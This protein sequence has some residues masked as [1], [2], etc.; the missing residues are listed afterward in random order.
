MVVDDVNTHPLFKG[1]RWGGSIVGLPLKGGGQVRAVMNVAYE[2][3]H[4]FAPEELRALEL[5]ADQAA[6]A[7]ENARYMAETERQLRDAQLLHRAGE[8]LN[9]T[10]SLEETLEQLADF[11]IQALD[12]QVCTISYVNIEKDE[13]RVIVD[14]DAMPETHVLPET[15]FHLSNHPHLIEMLREKRSLFFRRDAP[16]LNAE[17]AANMDAY[18]WKALMVTP[19]LAGEQIIGIVELGDQQHS[20]NFTPEQV[21]LAESLAHQAASALENA[22]LFQETQRRAEQLAVLNRIARRVNT[23]HTL[24]EMLVIIE[25][26]TSKVLASDASYIALYDAARDEFDFRRVV[27]YGEVR[28]TFRIPS[29]P[30]FTREIIA[31]ARALRIDDYAEYA[32][33]ENPPQF[34]GDATPLHSWLGV[35][36]RS[37]ERVLGVISLQSKQR[38]AFGQAEEQLL[39]TIADQV[40]AP[41]ERVLRESA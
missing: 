28:P 13:I 24:D 5:L 35:P 14:R 20:R 27:D 26:E 31:H 22:R 12:V 7:L 1:W 33:A 34:Y 17:T 9:R 41:M 18:H 16:S 3:P 2:L 8:A 40:A 37:G 10:L 6:V 23:A 30:S 25:S 38:A 39:Q 32:P 4:R 36:I 19:L 15:I 11:F 29:R 21:R